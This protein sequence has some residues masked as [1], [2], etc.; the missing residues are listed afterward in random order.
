MTDSKTTWPKLKRD[1]EG[2]I[3][4]TLRNL[5]CKAGTIRKGRAV[6]LGHYY[7]GWNIHAVRKVSGCP[8][9]MSR[10]SEHDLELV[11]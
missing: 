1:A 7:R 4:L 3:A 10:V 2:R 9:H 5:N 6:K 8:S 11:S